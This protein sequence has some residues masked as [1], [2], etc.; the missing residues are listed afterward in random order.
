MLQN[1]RF[2]F[3]RV[4]EFEHHEPIASPMALKLSQSAHDTVKKGLLVFTDVLL[5]AVYLHM[6]SSEAICI[7]GQLGYLSLLHYNAD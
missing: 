7:G 5:I 4:V 3:H 1:I 6:S 2:Q